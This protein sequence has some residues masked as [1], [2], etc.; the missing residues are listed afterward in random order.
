VFSKKRRERLVH[1]PEDLGGYRKHRNG[2]REAEGAKIHLVGSKEKRE[3]SP[4]CERT[5]SYRLRK[6][7]VFSENKNT[8]G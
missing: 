2:G 6:K 1:D 4:L 8:E 3:Q 5:M 7:R